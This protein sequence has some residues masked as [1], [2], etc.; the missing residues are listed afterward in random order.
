[1]IPTPM[2]FS[3][4]SITVFFVLNFGSTPA[5]TVSRGLALCLEHGVTAA[6]QSSRQGRVLLNG[7]AIDLPPVLD[8]LK[9][10]APEPVSVHLES[11]LPLGCGFGVSAAG[12]LSTA[13]VLNRRYNLGRSREQ[14]ALI[15]HA[16]EVNHRTGVGDVAAQIHGGIVFRRCLTGPFDALRLDSVRVPGLY[17]K[18]FGPI[19]TSAVLSSEP[20]VAAIVAA[21]GRAIAWLESHLDTVTLASLL[22]RS[23]LFAE[24]ASLLTDPAV[25]AAIRHIQAAGGSATMVMLGQTVVATVPSAEDEGWA[26]CNL[27]LEGARLLP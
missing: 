14:L 24:E 13:F 27:D 11:P 1:M 5:E 23:V 21:G 8:V 6:V 18:S 25:L 12:A 22:D 19:S 16:A 20:M 4:G 3:P 15:A 26:E 7:V 9:E 10:L 2:A 17:Y